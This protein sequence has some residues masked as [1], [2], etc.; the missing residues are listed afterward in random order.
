M[1]KIALAGVVV[2]LCSGLSAFADVT[3][4]TPPPT[5]MVPISKTYADVKAFILQL[6]KDHPDTTQ[7]FTL[8]GSDSGDTV[9]GLKFGNGPVH[10][11]VVGTHHGNEYGAT[12]VTKAF[13][14]SM[15]SNPIPGQTMYVIP[16]LNIGGYN[17]RD[18]YE[19]GGDHNAHDPN[20][21]YP[22]PCGTDGPFMLK[23]T[24][25]MADFVDK[26][27]IIASA[28]L[29]TFTPAVVYPWG[30]STHDLDTGYT[31]IF[32]MLAQAS[33]VESGYAIGNSTE[34]IYPADGCYEDYVWW[35]HGIWSLLW[36]LGDSHTPTDAEV[37]QL[38]Q[39]NVP[40]LRRMMEQ[41]PTKRADK[42][43]FTGKCDTS[44]FLQD[45][46]IE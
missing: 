33:T 43:D 15:A 12:E 22:G 37:A 25:A 46:R 19:Q 23:D 9:L 30:I 41:A 42:H 6:A 26:E 14:Y 18:R 39:V 7:L 16:V 2:F 35:K 20:R 3:P 45:R 10:N 38:E 34:L 4:G 36:E 17:A 8:G 28:T 1:K 24:K 32:K 11:V 5:L 44:L 29:H 21:D 31:D 27:N 40:G 13:A